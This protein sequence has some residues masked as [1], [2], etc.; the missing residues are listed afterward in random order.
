MLCR[1]ARVLTRALRSLLLL[2]L[3][4]L[5]LRQ[6]YRGPALYRHRTALC[7][8]VAHGSRRRRVV[9]PWCV[10][11][12][13]GAVVRVGPRDTDAAGAGEG[14]S[15]RH[16]RTDV[17][18]SASV[19]ATADALCRLTACKSASQQKQAY[20]AAHVTTRSGSTITRGRHGERKE[21]KSQE[22]EKYA[23]PALRNTQRLLATPATRTVAVQALLN[24]RVR[25]RDSRVLRPR[26]VYTVKALVPE[27]AGQSRNRTRHKHQ[28]AHPCSTVT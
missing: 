16:I 19:V 6:L 25:H 7:R 14:V 12:G 1:T 4:L 15:W 22:I 10:H 27:A 24:V 11:V 8:P 13:V 3:L 26:L 28:L 17:T 18:G 23:T 5:L 9:G 20:S 2:L 21:I